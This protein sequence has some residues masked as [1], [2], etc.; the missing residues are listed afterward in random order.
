MEH[1][2]AALTALIKKS[3]SLLSKL[4]D[5]QAPKADH[6]G[7]FAV[8]P[9]EI[10]QRIAAL[11]EPEAAAAL[12]FACKY[13][14]GVIGTES[15]LI[16]NRCCHPG[17]IHARGICR[18]C[19]RQRKVISLM[20][21]DVD[22]RKATVCFRHGIIHIH[23]PFWK[24][25]FASKDQCREGIIFPFRMNR[26]FLIGTMQKIIKG[27]QPVESTEFYTQLE[28]PRLKHAPGLEH[29]QA[30][31]TS[32][33]KVI[34]SE[35]IEAM[36][37][38]I[39]IPACCGFSPKQLQDLLE[40]GYYWPRGSPFEALEIRLPH[41]DDGRRPLSSHGKLRLNSFLPAFLWCH[42]RRCYIGGC[43]GGVNCV[44]DYRTVQVEP[45][46]STGVQIKIDMFINLGYG[47]IGRAL[48]EEASSIHLLATRSVYDPRSRVQCPEG[49]CSMCRQGKLLEKIVGS[50]FNDHEMMLTR[51]RENGSS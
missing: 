20:G 2:Q 35:L 42:S 6:S 9:R 11:A 24:R 48:M 19:V 33:A 37:I 13:L 18:K 31:F 15:W 50:E 3:Q 8:L 26:I 14:K 25:I 45:F 22:P 49:S 21:R 46:K 39:Q 23:Q 30:D 27:Y 32:Y 17:P 34:G 38:R 43:S 47:Y 16:L 7:A 1:L 44:R 40:T 12:I 10:I 51:A 4:R 29:M 41:S 36:Q 28:M 5:R